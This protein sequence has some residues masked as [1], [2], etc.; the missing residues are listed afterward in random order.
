[1]KIF[2]AL[3]CCALLAWPQAT[4]ASAVVV[5]RPPSPSAE[6]AET[7]N[8][9]HGE[10]I[11][12]GLE[13]TQIERPAAT[14]SAATDSRPWLEQLAGQ[15][16]AIA[17]IEMLGEDGVSGVD[18]W[19]RKSPGRFEVTRINADHDGTNSSARL[20]IRV[21]EALRASLVELDLAKRYL[22]AERAAKPPADR[23]LTPFKPREPS[24]HREKIGLEMGPSLLVS[25]GGVGPAV[26]PTLRVDWAAQPTLLIEVAMAAFGSHPSVTTQAGTATV[27]RD[28][29]LVGGC[30]RPWGDRRWW[31]FFSIAAGALRTSAAGEAGSEM[32]THLVENWSLLTDV[33]LGASVRFFHSYHASLAAHVQLA[34]PYVAIHF[35]D[36][37]AA[38]A[39]RPN[40][41][42]TLALGA[43]L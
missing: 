23:A 17:V 41:L 22:H 36:Q 21:L 40:L 38:T 5:V 27:A 35:G 29:A 13:D 7:L 8:L 26:L 34:Q 37:L 32:N 31:P 30:Y 4:S 18:V 20:A 28:Y 42:L 1:M 16:E 9:I 10:L 33:G 25:P 24:R 14:S 6:A 12:V 43:W 15:R 11:S 3:A 2:P 39:G 19:V